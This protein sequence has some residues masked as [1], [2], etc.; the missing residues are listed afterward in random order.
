MV[1]ANRR[2]FLGVG[3][4]LPWVV[5]SAQA[6]VPS[7]DAPSLLEDM[8]RYL[9]FGNKQ[10]GG[11]G[12][13]KC[14]EWLTDELSKCGYAVER[15][16]LD[17]PFFT[18][19]SASLSCAEAQASLLPQPIVT[20]TGPK[21]RTGP[22][23][24]VDASGQSHAPLQNAIALIDLPHAR[25]SSLTTPAVHDPVHAAFV[26]GAQAA[27]IIT[28]GP[29]GQRIALNADGNQSMFP[30]PVA[31]LAPHDAQPFLRAAMQR[32]P[33]TMI[34]DGQGG[35]RRAFNVIGRMDRGQK[36]WIVISTPRS[37]WFS[38]GAE[39]GPGIAIW[40]DLARW[41]ATAMADFN[42]AFLCNSGH[43]YE[44][45]G[46]AEAMNKIA[47]DPQTTSFWLHLGANIAARDWHHLL[48]EE[49][50]LPSA[51]S[52]RYLS[53]T[54]E[55]IPLAAEIFAGQAG[56]EAPISTQGF[57]AGELK[58]IIKAGYA[59]VAGVFGAHRYHHVME[60]DE[61]CLHPVATAH[62]A[63]SFRTL[64]KSIE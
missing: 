17:V 20:T 21:G 40:L 42:L 31:I 15:Q 50:P 33:A 41:A 7:P 2:T 63:R 29:T 32:P 3:A 10:S 36:R 13:Q 28:N 37:G 53:A 62:A 9:A 64:L 47:P 49:M 46:A 57:V 55:L 25:W 19:T 61:R 35:R 16:N 56:L 14:G 39:R 22:L 38:C 59:S 58:E 51:D 44:N 26:A 5:S 11:D 48:G 45:L 27:I 52:Q 54:P 18:A 30:G 23:V 43:E 12:D 6:Q 60:D 34:I 4:A 24:R 8:R 1:R